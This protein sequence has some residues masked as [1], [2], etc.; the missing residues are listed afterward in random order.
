MTPG[1]TRPWALNLRT[2]LELKTVNRDLLKSAERYLLRKGKGAQPSKPPA[3]PA[4]APIHTGPRNPPAN[5]N[6]FEG[7]PGPRRL[8]ERELELRAHLE[9]LPTGLAEAR[10][11]AEGL[12]ELVLA[13]RAFQRWRVLRPASLLD[14]PTP[15][16]LARSATN[17]CPE[18]MLR[19]ASERAFSRLVRGDRLPSTDL[20]VLFERSRTLLE[21]TALALVPDHYCESEPAYTAFAFQSAKHSVVLA[22]LAFSDVL[23]F[24]SHVRVDG[25]DLSVL[26]TAAC[27]VDDTPAGHPAKALEVALAL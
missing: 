27:F 26:E 19:A 11:Y 5:V 21:V 18:L 23:D 13:E 3:A 25:I 8:E 10:T 9:H 15:V 2:D 1:L 17:T 16:E 22:P 7:S 12:K 14:V 24:R 20:E 4:T 6:P